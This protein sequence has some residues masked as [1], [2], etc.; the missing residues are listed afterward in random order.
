VAHF[1]TSSGYFT[2]VSERQILLG[3][4]LSGTAAPCS[5]VA[6]VVEELFGANAIKDEELCVMFSCCAPRLQGG[7]C[8]SRTAQ[9]VRLVRGRSSEGACE[10]ARG[11]VVA[12]EQ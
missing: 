12:R 3:F 8:G 11:T 10:R 2:I 6:L 9:R 7:A 1:R 4:A 5:P